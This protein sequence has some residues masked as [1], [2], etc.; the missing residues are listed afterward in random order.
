MR[1]PRGIS[2]ARTMAAAPGR[3]AVEQARV[4]AG[5]VVARVQA[6]LSFQVAT[7]LQGALDAVLEPGEQLAALVLLCVCVQAA[8]MVGHVQAETVRSVLVVQVGQTLQGLLV[9]KEWASSSTQGL[10]LGFLLNTL[11]LCVPSVL[12]LLSPEFVAS[13]YVQNALSVWLFQY[14]SST[15]EVLARVDFGVSPAYVCLLAFALS[16]GARRLAA[17]SGAEAFALFKYLARAWHMLLVDWLLRTL[18]HSTGGLQRG[19]QIALLAMVVVVVDALALESLSL[20]RDV[21]GY[22]VFRIAGELQGL[23]VL[24]SDSASALGAALLAFCA[25]TGLGALQLHSRVTSSAAEVFFVASVNVL[26]QSATSGEAGVAQQLLRAGLVCVLA[27]AVQKEL[28]RGDEVD[29]EGRR[30]GKGA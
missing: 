26:V 10:V 29:G 1:V 12:E 13:A 5:R 28:A 9:Y 22:T 17:G 23:G 8:A 18:A 25:H 27:Y 6:A 16:A 15:R 11:G 21:R 3:S 7:A 19:L 2:G 30:G 20:M 14:A 4:D 24:S